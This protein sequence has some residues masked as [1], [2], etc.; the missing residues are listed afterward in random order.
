MFF[1]ICCLKK[2]QERR[3]PN[4]RAGPGRKLELINI[5]A[6]GNKKYEILFP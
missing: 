5:N 2:K 1:R 3:A 4:T 6:L